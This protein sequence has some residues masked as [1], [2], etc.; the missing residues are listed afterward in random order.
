MKSFTKLFDTQVKV[1]L[2]KGLPSM[3]GIEE[4]IFL[5]EYINPLRKLLPFL[6]QFTKHSI[7]FVI[8]I[9]DCFVSITKQAETICK[10]KPVFGYSEINLAYIRPNRKKRPHLLAGGRLYEDGE[11]YP[12]TPYLACG[13]KTG[14]AKQDDDDKL[15]L[16]YEEGI[17][18]ASL[19]PQSNM[20]EV[21]LL[22]N[23]YALPN[24][25]LLYYFVTINIKK[26]GSLLRYYFIEYQDI[27]YLNT[28]RQ[29]WC[30]KRLYVEPC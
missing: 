29:A 17:A 26:A 5:I 13:I 6:N 16:S 28:T 1:L 11:Y 23:H 10:A 15:P 4:H 12:R 18:V 19:F 9:P 20:G 22:G 3:I 30:E 2:K 14:L 8:V 21:A 24:T 27:E 7:P 25:N